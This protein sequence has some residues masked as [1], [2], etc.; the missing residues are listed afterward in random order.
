MRRNRLARCLLAI[1][2]LLLGACAPATIG[3]PPATAA[4]SRLPGEDAGAAGL[5]ARIEAS[6]CPE[7]SFTCVTLTVPLD[8]FS[9][10][11]TATIPVVFA[12]QPASGERRGMF[13]VAT[14]GPGSSGVASADWYT[15]GFDPAIAEHF[16]IIFFDQRG[17][18][19]SGGLQCTD[20]AVAFYRADYRA[21][22]PA[23]EA[24]LAAAARTFARDCVAQ[25][26]SPYLLPY[27]GTRQAV[28]D[29]EAFRQAVGDDRFWLYGESYGTYYA[30]AYAAA[31]PDRL[32]GLILDG[33]VDPTLTG[34][35]FLREQ[36]QAFADVLQAT[37][38]ACSADAACTADMGADALA[39]YDDLAARLARSPLPYDFPLPSGRTERR[40][41]TLSDL[42]ATAAYALYAEDSRMLLQRGLAAA[43]HGDLTLLARLLYS[44][45]G[46][47]P[48]TQQAILDPTWS[49]AVYYA[50]TCSDYAY[51]AGTPA[52]RAEQYLRAGDAVDASVP[53]LGSVFYGDLPCVFWPTQPDPLP[54]APLVATGIPTLVLGA[55]ADP[56]TPLANGERVYRRLADG[57]LITTDGGAH[58]TFGWGSACPDELVSAFLIEGRVPRQRR[59]RCAGVLAEAYVPLAPADARAFADPLEA[60]L[61]ADD[62]IYY[63]P[64]YYYWDGVTPTQVGCP[65]GGT[66]AFAAVDDGEAFSLSE[67]AFSA[68]WTMT[69]IG[70]YS[71]ADEHFHLDVAVSGLAEGHLSY[72]SAADGT[73]R[74]TGH[75]AGQQVDL[76][77]EGEE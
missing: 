36:A 53:R 14:G 63:L 18:G 41:L 60:L 72:S 22:T 17:V 28:E 61:A 58:V 3:E 20:A 24:A 45:L 38:E 6:P 44:T 69:G 71:A 43:A 70:T 13:V 74:V 42:E 30:Q 21:E 5:L 29:L 32:A 67:C 48:E 75:Y 46:V 62:A 66:L 57:Y 76:A 51:F 31:H 1:L 50:V 16:D 64:E 49:D 9:P 35:E 23:Q 2:L 65:Y 25:M 55:T 37:L 73:A 39:T 15:A 40:F 68:G 4:P 7:S 11:M 12:V 59:T 33:T 26:G 54:L 56:A 10:A 34:P 52:E 47:D 27:L 8:H 19:A 77:Y